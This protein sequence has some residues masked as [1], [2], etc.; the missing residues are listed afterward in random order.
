MPES[1]ANVVHVPVSTLKW[2][3]ELASLNPNDLIPRIQAYITAAEP[4]QFE[5]GGKEAQHDQGQDLYQPI[6][7]AVDMSRA[8][9]PMP[10]GW[11][12]QTKGTGSTYRLCDPKGDRLAIPDSPYLWE[13]LERMARDVNAA[14]KRLQERYERSGW[15]HRVAYIA[16]E[17]LTELSVDRADAVR[18]AEG[19]DL[20]HIRWM[21]KTLSTEP[22]TFTDTKACRWLG[23]VQ[24]WRVANGYTT[25][26]DEARRNLESAKSEKYQAVSTTAHI[27]KLCEDLTEWFYTENAEDANRDTLDAMISRIRS[28]HIS[29]MHDPRVL[30]LMA[31]YVARQAMVDFDSVAGFTQD[32][33]VDTQRK[34]LEYAR[35]GG[36]D[37]LLDESSALAQLLAVHATKDHA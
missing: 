19:N 35:L 20:D 37:E 27:D 33:L 17:L 25:L 8:Y 11:E 31:R 1:S 7:I 28:L 6:E 4:G 16:R 13:E 34:A 15:R 3:L 24:G 26:A 29:T 23:Y 12:I 2:W 22:L 32:V 14:W 9:I 36:P 21:L 18:S 10:G 30:E 5:R